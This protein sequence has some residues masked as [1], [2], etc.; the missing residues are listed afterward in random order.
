MTTE[1][2]L[3]ELFTKC[4]NQF[5]KNLSKNQN[6]LLREGWIPYRKTDRVMKS[7]CEADC[8]LFYS[9]PVKFYTCC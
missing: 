9:Q 3:P 5:S 6:V 8:L 1:P 7:C 4:K 2:L